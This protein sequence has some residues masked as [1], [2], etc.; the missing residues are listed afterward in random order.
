MRIALISDLHANRPATEAVLAHID[1]Q[2]PDAIYCL[3]DLVGY[4]PEPAAVI[5]LIRSRGIPC[6]EGNHDAGVNGHM[7]ADHFREPNRS[8]IIRTRELLGPDQLAYLRDLPLTR[9]LETDGLR[10]IFTHASPVQPERWNYLN[11]AV[12]CRQVLGQVPHDI[13]FVGHTHI[14]SVVAAELGVFGVE[15]GMRY[16]MNPGAIGQNRDGDLRAAYG[17]FDTTAFTWTPFR[18]PYPV[19]ETLGAYTALGI[20]RDTAERLLHV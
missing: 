6:V 19:E 5:E 14:P 3:G 7:P 11:S 1:R 12:K 17:L 15:K 16:V 2:K 9:E 18:V 4:G 13:V 20:D 10:L 8:L